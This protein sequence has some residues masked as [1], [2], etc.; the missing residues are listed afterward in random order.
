[1]ELDAIVTGLKILTAWLAFT[2][3]V[4]LFIYAAMYKGKNDGRDE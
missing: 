4:C 2:T 1:M 3:I